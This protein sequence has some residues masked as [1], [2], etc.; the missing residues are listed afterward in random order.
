MV[1]GRKEVK[2]NGKEL[3]APA[4]VVQWVELWPANGKVAGLIPAQGTCLGC[5]PGPQ[6]EVCERQPMDV[7]LPLFLPPFSSK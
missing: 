4:V 1:S 7:S 5:R 2:L 6:L 3:S